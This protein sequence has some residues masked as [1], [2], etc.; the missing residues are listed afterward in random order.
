MSDGEATAV[1]HTAVVLA[2]LAADGYAPGGTAR[3]A[4][5]KPVSSSA[6]VAQASL[7]AD[8]AACPNGLVKALPLSS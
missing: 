2:V 4:Q 1:G 3:A 6:I 7:N 5:R 8:G